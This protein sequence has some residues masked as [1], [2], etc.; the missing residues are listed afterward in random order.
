LPLRSECRL[1]AD[2]A[3]CSRESS[4]ANGWSRLR[5]PGCSSSS[6]HGPW[7]DH[8]LLL[9][10]DEAHTLPSSAPPPPLLLIRRC[11]TSPAVSLGSHVTL[12]ARLMMGRIAQP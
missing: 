11:F 5:C 4:G 8:Q 6:C 7:E 2:C 1:R 12:S 9:R 10:P 3:A